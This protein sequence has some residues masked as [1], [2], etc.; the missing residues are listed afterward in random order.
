MAERFDVAP[1]P[2][3]LEALK[4][5]VEKAKGADWYGAIALAAVE[6]TDEATARD[7]Y[8]LALEFAR[9]AMTA[10]AKSHLSHLRDIADSKREDVEQL[11]QAW[12]D[13]EEERV[14]LRA[15]PRDPGVNA[16]F[17]KFLCFSKDDWKRGLDYL[18][19]A[20]EPGLRSVAESEFGDPQ[21]AEEQTKLGDAWWSLSR[22][23]P[24]DHKAHFLLRARHWYQRA[25]DESHGLTELKLK[26]KIREIDR[27]AL[28]SERFYLTDMQ[29]MMTG[30]GPWGFGKFGRLGSTE[31]TDSIVIQGVASP[32]GLGMH[33]RANGFAFAQYRLDGDFKTFV[34]SV[35]L[36][37]R[38]SEGVVSFYVYGDGKVLWQSVP[39]Q[40]S[41][42]PQ[43]CRVRV[44]N[45]RLLELRAHVEGP[46]RGAQACWLEPFLLKST[47]PRGL[48]LP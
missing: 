15:A 2:M 20:E 10:A 9:L 43:S 30:F 23:A 7:E 4:Q 1:V 11:K 19:A 47:P 8:D 14:T 29:E 18:A 22:E 3:K 26:E 44:R 36:A 46:Q 6:L 38:G 25:V 31:R 5:S 28:G 32:R 35:A 17:G 16:A 40:E 37:G 48:R 13:L 12:D 21:D 41:Q 39:T 24:G 33:P 42:R 45:I 27:T 34:S